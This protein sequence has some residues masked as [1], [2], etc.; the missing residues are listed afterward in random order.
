VNGETLKAS[1]SGLVAKCRQRMRPIGGGAVNTMRLA[2]K[3]AGLPV[4][5]TR[6][7]SLWRNPEFRTEG[8]TTDAA[9]KQVQTGLRDL[10]S[11]REF[12]G[13]SQTEIAQIEDREATN[14]P[15][16]AALSREFRAG[17]GMTGG[18]TAPGQ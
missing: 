3:A 5:D 13:M 8:E 15:V 6:M 4:P 10:R 11:A 17:A 9:V 12:V 1:E 16:V 2:R 18:G 14:D 7:E